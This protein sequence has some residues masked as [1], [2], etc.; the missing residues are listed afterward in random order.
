VKV[1]AGIFLCGLAR[2]IELLRCQ[3]GKEGGIPFE[4]R[5][6]RG[7]PILSDEHIQG[8]LK[9]S[10]VVSRKQMV[11]LQPSGESLPPFFKGSNYP[12]WKRGVRGDFIKPVI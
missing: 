11:S 8:Q 1:T 5:Q 9:N 7:F 6:R 3:I 12:L 10:S 4:G 2:F